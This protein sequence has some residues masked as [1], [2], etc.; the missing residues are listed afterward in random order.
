MINLKPRYLHQELTEGT[1]M[2]YGT[3]IGRANKKLICEKCNSIKNIQIHHKNKNHFDN[4][5]SNLQALCAKC[6]QGWHNKNDPAFEIRKKHQS[7]TMKKRYAKKEIITWNKGLDASDPRV[8]KYAKTQSIRK[9]GMNL[10]YLHTPE[11]HRK[12]AFART[13]IP[14]TLEHRKN[15]SKSHKGKILSLEH[16][17]HISEGLILKRFGKGA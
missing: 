16:R 3:I 11:I 13:G 14:L 5:L 15:I 10:D 2:T 12:S 6:H 4:R 1:A 7:E 9:K 17:K 8:A